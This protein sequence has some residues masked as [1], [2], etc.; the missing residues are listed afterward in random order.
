M[1]QTMYAHVSKYI[2]IKTDKG[3]I[4]LAERSKQNENS[5]SFS[6]NNSFNVNVNQP[7][8]QKI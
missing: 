7:P 4:R 3:T 2:Y 6:V 5:K 8:N 1:T